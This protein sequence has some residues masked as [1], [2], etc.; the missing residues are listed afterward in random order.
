MGPCRTAVKPD[1]N[2]RS[3]LRTVVPLVALAFRAGTAGRADDPTGGQATA[4][5]FSVHRWEK[6][7]GNP[8]LPLGGGDFDVS[9]CIDPCVHRIGGKWHL[10]YSG[11]SS[12]PGKLQAFCGIGLA[13]SDDLKTWKKHGTEPDPEG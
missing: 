3:R 8:V 11:R 2:L 13:V 12:G 10:Y 9:C 1:T 6:H 4:A 5:A 7:P